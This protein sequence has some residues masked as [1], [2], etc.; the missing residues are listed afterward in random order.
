MTGAP[1]LFVE[2]NRAP[3][4]APADTNQPIWCSGTEY[5]PSPGSTVLD[6]PGSTVPGGGE[7]MCATLLC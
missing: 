3:V 1:R 7:R 5:A 6:A 2:M 4:D